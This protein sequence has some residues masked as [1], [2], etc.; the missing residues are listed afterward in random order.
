[1]GGWNTQWEEQR[2]ERGGGEGMVFIFFSRSFIISGSPA[3]GSSL[4]FSSFSFF[5]FSVSST[6][7]KCSIVR[8]VLL[9]C[10]IDSIN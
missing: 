7:S 2:G 1:M 8:I 5:F 3:S 9:L 10:C 4:P 6:L